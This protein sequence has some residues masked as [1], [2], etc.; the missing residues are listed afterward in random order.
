[1]TPS[2]NVRSHAVREP[3]MTGL[4]VERVAEVPATI[5]ICVSNGTVAWYR[6]GASRGCAGREWD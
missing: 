4:D 1:M 3:R 6:N 2:K 5:P